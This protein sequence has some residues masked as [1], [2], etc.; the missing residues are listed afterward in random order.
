MPT[1]TLYH[2]TAKASADDI[3]KY[4]LDASK[5]RRYNAGGEFWATTDQLTAEIFAQANPA[6]GTPAYL[7]FEVEDTVLKLLLAQNPVVSEFYSPNAYQFLP[8]S[9]DFLNRA[10]IK[11]HVVSLPSGLG[12]L[13]RA[14][15]IYVAWDIYCSSPEVTRSIREKLV[16]ES[17]SDRV[18]TL[19]IQSGGM[20]SKAFHRIGDYFESIHIVPKTD[21][22]QNT[23]RLVR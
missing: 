22:T 14:D 23:I 1:L 13:M 18:L 12:V 6:G 5:A 9:F 19:E 16:H 11:K 2:G 8:S 10:M 20:K 17:D 4:G 15:P 7:V 3:L 21:E